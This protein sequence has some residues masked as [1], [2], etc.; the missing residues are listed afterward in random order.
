M[1]AVGFESVIGCEWTLIADGI[2]SF[3]CDA[4]HFMLMPWSICDSDHADSA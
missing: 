3:A 4:D 2:G 1:L